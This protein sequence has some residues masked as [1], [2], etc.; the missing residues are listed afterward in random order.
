MLW[1][2]TPAF[3]SNYTFDRDTFYSGLNAEIRS[4]KGRYGDALR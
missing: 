4:L 1:E 3:F 2:D